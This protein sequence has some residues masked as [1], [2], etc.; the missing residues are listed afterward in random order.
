MTTAEFTA[1]LAQMLY[2][3]LLLSMPVILVAAGVGLVMALLQALT[4]IQEQ[5]L[6]VAVKL[7]AVGLTLFL[8]AGWAGREVY[9]YTS[10]IF[11]AVQKVGAHR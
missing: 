3:T 8:A 11:D 5:T 2:L 7:L 10:S 9:A 6:P 1:L 4:Q